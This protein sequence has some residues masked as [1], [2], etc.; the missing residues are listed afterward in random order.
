M[1]ELLD[2]DEAIR[3][4][5]AAELIERATNSTTEVASKIP[6]LVGF[7]RESTDDMVSMQIA[8]AIS[9]MCE[10]S[11]GV[12]RTY[13]GNIMG[14][15]EFLS[16]RPMTEDE[17][18]T[19]INA[20]A[21]H[22]FNTQVPQLT[23][24]SSFLRSSLPLLFKYLGKEGS[25]RWPAYT[26][27]ARV[28]AENPKMFEDYV[29]VIIEM[30]ARGSSE[31]SPPLMFLYKFKPVE[32]H[33]RIETLV[34]VYQKD[35]NLRSLLLS[36][37]LE[38]SKDKPDLLEPHLGMFVEGLNSPTTGSMNATIMSEIA[39]NNPGVVYPHLDSL[40]KSVDYVDALKYTVP[41]V[42]G[43][44]GRMS[45]DVAREVLPFLADLLKDADQN[46]AI[47]VLSEFINLG[48]M[49]RELFEP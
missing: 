42:L 14:T 31:L 26:V 11:P 16:S 9:I 8:H 27:V 17:G 40:K 45:D 3:R 25:A 33:S 28:A 15:L 32:Y 19:M 49:N 12:E 46:L 35:A 6:E 34:G 43:L 13:S 36:I 22:L 47:M 38:I 24:D 20:V 5:A 44:I 7:I 4:K 41:N 30:V 2:A 18:E 21:T 39:R 48:E 10:K 23:A 1:Q 37:F 29:G